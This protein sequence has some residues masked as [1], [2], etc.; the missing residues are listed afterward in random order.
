MAEIVLLSSAL[1]VVVV[2]SIYQFY[3]SR[4]LQ[5]SI[6]QQN[7]IIRDLETRVIAYN[8]DVRQALHKDTKDTKYTKAS[9]EFA[10]IEESVYGP[11][12]EDKCLERSRISE[13]P[14]SE[15]HISN[16]KKSDP[17]SSSPRRRSRSRSIDSVGS[18]D[19]STPDDMVIDSHHNSRRS[20]STSP[21]GSKVN[22]Q[23]SSKIKR[24]SGGTFVPHL[25]TID[26][27]RTPMTTT[28]LPGAPR[29][30]P[31]HSPRGSV[32]GASRGGSRIGKRI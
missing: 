22:S 12:P 20:H 24:L 5:F 18:A 10:E 14:Y 32:Q 9:E 30:S 13:R 25:E 19:L 11:L 16:L 2:N 27:K 21:H 26:S 8:A 6:K 7:A 15:I 31:I 1:T 29:S 3:R 28:K 17:N 23:V 4:K